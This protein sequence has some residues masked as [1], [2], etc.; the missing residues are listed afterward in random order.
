MAGSDEFDW[1][2]LLDVDGL[3]DTDATTPVSIPF[4]ITKAQKA[5]L[6]ELGYSDEAISMM[7]PEEAHRL[8][9]A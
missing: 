7:T 4:M 9:Q 8:L 6:R 3:V 2:K 1:T 5:K